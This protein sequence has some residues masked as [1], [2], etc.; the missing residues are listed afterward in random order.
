MHECLGINEILN[1][2]FSSIEDEHRSR[3]LYCLSHT[4]K[5]FKNPALDKLWYELQDLSLLFRILPA[6]TWDI[7]TS[8]G[9]DTRRVSA[10]V[11]LKSPRP[12][13]WARC[14]EYG[15]R[16]RKLQ[17]LS[18]RSPSIHLHPALILSIPAGVDL[19]PKLQCLGYANTGLSVALHD[20]FL[21]PSLTRVELSIHLTGDF[22]AF[23]QAFVN[24]LP[25]KAPNLRD[26]VE[27][28]TSESH[29]P[30]HTA[31]LNIPTQTLERLRRLHAPT[32]RLETHALQFLAHPDH[33]LE[34]LKVSN[35][36]EDLIA[37]LRNEQ[38]VFSR[39]GQLAVQCTRTEAV[40]TFLE[41]L[42]Q[43]TPLQSI[44]LGLVEDMNPGPADIRDVLDAVA[45]HRK[46]QL[47]TLELEQQE[48]PDAWAFDDEGSP[49]MLG[50][51][52]IR[53]LLPCG[54]LT[55]VRI[56]CKTV[57]DFSDSD[58]EELAEAWPRL[59]ILHLAPIQPSWSE[60]SV[61]L[62]GLSCFPKYC[63]DL[64]SLTIEFSAL[65]AT[66]FNTHYGLFN[67]L[68]CVRM[69]YLH[70]VGS[71]METEDVSGTAEFL[72]SI[73]PAL[74]KIDSLDHGRSRLW[75]SVALEMMVR[76]MMAR[77]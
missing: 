46:S 16:V 44:S 53:P 6:D 2:I 13:D 22:C 40:R 77:P 4:C 21:R 25:N 48:R 49:S 29:P 28:S 41:V 52:S 45:K 30:A 11:L 17:C 50:F 33:G 54:S 60:G 76:R 63:P 9:L 14:A 7:Q 57:Y 20:R 32:F 56:S 51:S 23:T 3:S 35:D 67:G 74:Q 73:F 66:Q 75:Q 27:V 69:S 72:L 42:P 8:A 59:R 68:G 61:S 39:L 62:H 55:E 24:S 12:S 5:A 38:G 65:S 70:V 19:F 34:G 71:G 26:I 10:M 1:N 37:L 15:Q 47:L 58:L 64:E 18:T 31:T 36:I 43:S